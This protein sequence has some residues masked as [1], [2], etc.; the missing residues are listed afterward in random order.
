MLMFLA[1][2]IIVQ[3]CGQRSLVVFGRLLL[4]PT[5]CICHLDFFVIILEQVSRIS[6]VDS[7]KNACMSEVLGI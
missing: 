7:W 5:G 3:C 6:N 4:R 2:C 1:I